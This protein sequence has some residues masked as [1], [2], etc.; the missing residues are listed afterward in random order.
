MNSLCAVTKVEYYDFF[1]N[2]LNKWLCHN[3]FDWEYR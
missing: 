3:N 1:N 2:K